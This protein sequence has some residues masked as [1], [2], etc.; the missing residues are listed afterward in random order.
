LAP[1][2]AR[3]APAVAS[4]SYSSLGEYA[5][6]G[7]RF[8][9]ERVLGLPPAHSA[10]GHPPPPSRPGPP[11]IRP[12]E[13]RGVLIH[14]LLEG[15]DFRRPSVPGPEAMAAAAARAGI[16]PAPGPDEAAELVAL[17]QSFAAG[18]LCARLGRAREVRRE[19]RFAF[20]LGSGELVTGAFDVLAREQGERMLIVDYKSDRLRGADPAAV[21]HDAYETQRLVYA[22]A[23]LRAGGA[24]AEVVHCFLER[25]GEPVSARFTRSDTGDLEQALERLASGVARHEFAVTATPYRELCAGCPAEGGLCSWSVAMTRRD[26]PDRLF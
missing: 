18:E 22:L 12:A 21:V 3:P 19:E 7:Y 26:S 8:Y 2:P 15:L 11:P 5:R 9:V 24:E 1:E 13:Q 25:P 10:A 16:V 14:A 20:L 23:A 4:L 6:C 17:V